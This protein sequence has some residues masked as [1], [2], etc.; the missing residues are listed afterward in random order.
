MSNVYI[1]AERR[2]IQYNENL[3][4]IAFDNSTSIPYFNLKQIY[5]LFG[6]TTHTNLI[7]KKY[8]FNLKNID[9]QYKIKYKNMNASTQFVNEIGLYELMFANKTKITYEIGQLMIS[10][11]LPSLRKYANFNSICH[12]KT[13]IKQLRNQINTQLN[14][15]K[16]IV[17]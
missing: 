16:L 15:Y 7:N 11:I 10:D 4:Y 14:E 8:I 13:K 5:T 6:Y 3:I 12:L 2:I 17:K 9:K 1:N